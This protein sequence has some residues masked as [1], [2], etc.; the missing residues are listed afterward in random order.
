MKKTQNRKA[1]SSADKA[2]LE[3]RHTEILM[4]LGECEIQ[5]DLA[6]QAK[7]ELKKELIEIHEAFKT[8][9]QTHEPQINKSIN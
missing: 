5:I 8:A 7:L 9:T 4:K 6:T 1:V 3:A 2:R